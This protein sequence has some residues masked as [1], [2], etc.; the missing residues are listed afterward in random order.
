MLS[1]ITD[2][3]PGNLFH[4]TFQIRPRTFRI[5][6]K[7]LVNRQVPFCIPCIL[8]F[9]DSIAQTNIGAQLNER[10]ISIVAH[11]PVAAHLVIGDLDRHRL[12]IIISAAGCPC[13]V[14]LLDRKSVV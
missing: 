8:Q 7:H 9:L 11:M 4:F 3:V 2:Y 12:I 14:A 5:A 6:G 1:Q 10:R 13:P